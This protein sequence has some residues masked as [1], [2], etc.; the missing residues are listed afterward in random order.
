MIDLNGCSVSDIICIMV[1]CEL[2]VFILSVFFFDVD[3]INDVFMIF[4]GQGVEEVE[5]F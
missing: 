2:N 3:G 1:E 4:V 5:C